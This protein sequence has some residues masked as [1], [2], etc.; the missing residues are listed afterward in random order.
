MTP[1]NIIRLIIYY[2]TMKKSGPYKTYKGKIEPTNLKNPQKYEGDINNIVYRSS[3]ERSAI[4]WLDQ[5]PEVTK[6]ASE[7]IFF[8]Y[9]N[10]VTGKRSKYYPD[11]YVE[12]ASGVCKIVE[13]KPKN[14]VS[15]P[16]E[17]KR[18]TARY[19]NEVSTYMI[20]QEKWKEAKSICDKNGLI[21]EV[22]TEDTLD[23]LGIR[24]NIV[25]SEKKQTPRTKKFVST[26]KPR[27]R[28]KRKS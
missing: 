8:Y 26:R 5:N 25:L 9:E 13:I 7:E 18:K 24:K 1:I 16:K 20:N 15:P 21:F 4:Y 17:P 10:P 3:W 22:W 2:A 19:I 11:L 12:Y 23:A 27:T 14:Q 28:P 6:Y